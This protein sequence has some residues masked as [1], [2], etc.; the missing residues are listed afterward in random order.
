MDFSL[1]NEIQ[2]R[3]LEALAEEARLIAFMHAKPFII[4]VVTIIGKLYLDLRK[5]VQKAYGRNLLN[6][7]IWILIN[8]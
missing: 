1:L 2:A 6:L 3:R 7:K 8:F 5:V 4:F